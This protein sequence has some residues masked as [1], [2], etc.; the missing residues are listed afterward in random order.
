[1]AEEKQTTRMEVELLLDCG[2][3]IVIPIENVISVPP[4]GSEVT[5]SLCGKKQNIKRVGIPYYVTHTHVDE[6]KSQRSILDEKE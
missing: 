2:E 6:N 3:I 5:C 1:M 4:I